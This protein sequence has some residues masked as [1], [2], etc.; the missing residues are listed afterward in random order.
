[1]QAL[2]QRLRERGTESPETLKVRID[3]AV[4]ELDFADR[5]DATIVNDD[6]DKACDEAVSLVRRFLH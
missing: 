5:F 2:E 3:K 1:V 6:L 4:H